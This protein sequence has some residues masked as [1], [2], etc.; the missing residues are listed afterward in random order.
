[1]NN[2][3]METKPTK[4]TI[5]SKSVISWLQQVNNADYHSRMDT[6]SNVDHYG[7]LR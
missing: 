3:L 4:Q 7:G 6:P 5:N 2:E 1:M